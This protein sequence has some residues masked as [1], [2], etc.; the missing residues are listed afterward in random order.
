MQY[1]LSLYSMDTVD[2]VVTI[3]AGAQGDSADVDGVEV[4]DPVA[5]KATSKWNHVHKTRSK[6]RSS[7]SHD[8]L[9]VEID[10]WSK[11]AA[12]FTNC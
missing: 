8:Y 5:E 9:S 2:T 1:W 4:I 10:S 12:D 7:C 6:P 3:D 11:P